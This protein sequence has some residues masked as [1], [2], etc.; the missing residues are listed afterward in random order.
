MV[1]FRVYMNMFQTN[2]IIANIIGR[3]INLGSLYMSVLVFT[4]FLFPYVYIGV[5]GYLSHNMGS[6]IENARLLGKGELEIFAK[7]ILPISKTAILSGMILVG[8]EVLGDFGVVQYLGVP[9]FATAI[10]KSWIGFK[11]FDSAIRLSGML[12]IVAFILLVFKK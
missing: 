10:F 4:L 7:V 3:S 2:G 12:V 8:M 1:E 5:K 9:T 11:D 6:Y